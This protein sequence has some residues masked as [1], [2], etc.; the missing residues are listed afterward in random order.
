[1][2]LHVT[3]EGGLRCRTVDPASGASV[4][5][6]APLSFGGRGEL[7]SPTDLVAAA[8]ASCVLTVIGTVAGRVGLD[9]AGATAAVSKSMADSPAR[10]IGQLTVAVELPHPLDPDQLGRLQAAVRACPVHHSLHPDI[11]VAV[12]IQAPQPEG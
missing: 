8:L 3:Y 6:D 11:D 10:R 4:S 9:V 2:E 7:L 12:T 5:T 1:M